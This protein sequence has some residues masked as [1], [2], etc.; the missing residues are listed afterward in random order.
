MVLEAIESERS[1]VRLTST[2]Y[3][4]WEFQFRVFVE[5]KGLLGILLG[6][7]PKPTE[8]AAS[9]QEIA[10]WSQNDARVRSLLLGSIDASTCLSLRLFPT[11]NRMWRHLSDLYST[12]NASHQFEIQCAL[13]R[14]EQG[15]KS[16]TEYF[17]A[18]QEIWTEQDLL[19]AV[20]RPHVAESSDAIDE[21]QQV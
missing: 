8:G 21:R 16:V 15:D 10:T 19:S 20:L 7:S 13:A 2:N 12:V 14:L 4:L 6:T 11:A 5:G 3:A 18:A 1:L 9:V 17:N